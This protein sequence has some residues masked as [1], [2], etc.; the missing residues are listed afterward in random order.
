MSGRRQF[1]RYVSQQIFGML[2]LSCYI[3]ADTFFI[4]AGMG[5]GGLASLNLAISVYSVINGAGLMAGIGGATRYAVFRA[6]GDARRANRAFTDALRLGMLA[7]ALFAALGLFGTE[8][9]CRA[10]GTDAQTHAMTRVYLRTI[11]LFAPC[12]ILNNLLHAFVRNDGAPRLAMAAMLAGSFSNILLDY[13]FLFPLR[14]GMFGAAFATGLAPIVSMAVL[15]P[16]FARGGCGFRP[17]AC[18][19]SARRMAGVAVPGLA[20]LVMEVSTG[21][22]LM[23]SNRVI[24]ALSGTVGVAAYGVVANLALV[25]TA[26]FSGLAQGIQPLVS[27]RCGLGDRAGMRGVLRRAL[28]V[29]LLLAAGLYAMVFLLAEPVTAA[30]NGE[31]NGA[32]RAL[33]VPGLRIYFS[34][35]LFAGVNIVL[36]AF[37]SAGGR[38][39]EGFALSLLR[40]CAAPL[41]AVAALGAWLGMTGVWLAFPCA[42]LAALFLALRMARRA[43]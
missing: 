13:L 1:A 24:L 26:L 8:P 40:G 36:A 10:L 41:P 12:F 20:A 21:L 18:G 30:F 39:R 43:G 14:L 33:A 31:G 32:L 35:F 4:S 28:R 6:Q 25:A 16:H 42:E 38:E 7:A 15:S 27:E 9:L 29:A 19:L 37:F 5:A 17:V 34:G 22:L 2:G 11:L 3:L 23:V